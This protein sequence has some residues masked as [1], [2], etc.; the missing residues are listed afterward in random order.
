M[1]EVGVGAAVMDFVGSD[2][3]LY[4]CSQ[5]VLC[6]DASMHTRVVDA[7]SKMMKKRRLSLSFLTRKQETI[8][9][10]SRR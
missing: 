5:D 7:N 8:C 2:T 10:A 6:H 1:L 9:V 4:F 3:P